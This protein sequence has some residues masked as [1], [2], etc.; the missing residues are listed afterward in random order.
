V[1]S[2]FRLLLVLLS[3]GLVSLGL[4]Q[5][6]A[7]TRL[8][9][10]LETRARS[11]L[12]READLVRTAV[13]S[14]P[15]SDSLADVLGQSGDRVTLLDASGKIVGDSYLPASRLDSMAS[16]A[17]RP[18][19]RSA[20]RGDTASVTGLSEQ[21]G[22]TLLYVALPASGGVVR[23]ARPLAEV[24]EPAVHV[25]R[26]LLAVAIAY[27]LLVAFLVV[28]LER[29][30]TGPARA[31][32]HRLVPAT[33]G[34]EAGP[35]HDE[36]LWVF[37]QMDEGIAVL[38]EHGTVVRVNRSMASMTAPQ[39]PVGRPAR[40]LF[41]DPAVL[42]A[43]DRGVEGLAAETETSSGG[44]TF[45]VSVRPHESRILLLVR[46]LTRLRRLEGVRR[47]FVANASHELKTP[48]TS[49]LGFAETL[50]DEDLP[51]DRR[52]EFVRRIR[53]NATRM[54]RLIDDL[55]DLSRI[56][57]GA[58][59][60]RPELIEV[61]AAARQAW[62]ELGA[63]GDRDVELS[64]RTGEA[65]T[66]W[67]DRAA[68]H[69][70][71]RNLLDNALRYAPPGTAI[72]VSSLPSEDLVRIEVSDRGPG[73]PL[74]ERERVFERFWRVD[75]GRSRAEGGTGLGLS[76]VRHLVAGHGGSVGIEG[77]PGE[78]TTVWF[79]LPAPGAAA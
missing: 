2:R 65:P 56:E 28:P 20:L 76:I 13:G 67:A 11:D 46:D 34:E 74:A 14:Q 40:S 42:E 75:P 31:A 79:T 29:L 37:D 21:L 49:I 9:E 17:G 73:I 60:P 22:S 59:Q 50:Q 78:G 43:L 5:G 39:H 61:E 63:P 26:A 62:V 38:D 47:D 24:V 16:E 33:P 36:L 6:Y 32:P 7:S 12:E 3:G 25:R 54:R 77:A 72:G 45:L 41:R 69:Q 1:S 58:W 64:S 8:P 15:F 52:A 44:R 18:E 30:V 48:L 19:V 70:I 68:L 57:S 35:K 23:V 51:P 55:L 66:V 53:D 10:L 27:L 71:L 4:V